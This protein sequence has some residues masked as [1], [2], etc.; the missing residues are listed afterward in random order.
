MNHGKSRTLQQIPAFQRYYLQCARRQL[1]T[2]FQVVKVLVGAIH[3]N[4][5]GGFPEPVLELFDRLNVVADRS[6]GKS[7]QLKK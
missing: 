4:V 1:F 7:F 5:Y 6:F 3:G 2:I